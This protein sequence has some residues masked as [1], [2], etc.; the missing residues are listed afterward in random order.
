MT[1]TITL[2]PGDGVGPEISEA[3]RRVVDATGAGIDWEVLHAGESV[4]AKNNGNPLPDHVLESIRR[5]KTALKG[6]IT[7][8]IAT[9][10]RSVN[11]ALRQELELYCCVRP[12]KTYPGIHS[13]FDKVDFVIVRENM[14]DLYAGIEYEV[15][16][17]ET[18]ALIDSINS[19]F[20]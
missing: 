14:E 3:T 5:N 11:V 18:L 9:G 17:P 2:I 10:F 4:M 6:P 13:R 16:K 7:T 20:D 15:G 8:P 12:C 19:R 1:Y